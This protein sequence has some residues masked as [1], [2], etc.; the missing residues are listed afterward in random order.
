MN[1]TA[2]EPTE[3]PI[4]VVLDTNVWVKELLLN[5]SL[6]AAFLYSLAK[7]R[8]RI[9]LPEITEKEVISITA[10]RGSEAVQNIEKNLR[11]VR[12]LIGKTE[13]I[14][15]IDCITLSGRPI[16]GHSVGFMSG[17]ITIGRKQIRH[18][19]KRRIDDLEEDD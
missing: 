19:I 3:K 5:S 7:L 18:T 11:F 15:A 4:C 10:R 6:G 2:Q 1:H 12:S 14:N 9:G 13:G 8:G 16:I 17:S